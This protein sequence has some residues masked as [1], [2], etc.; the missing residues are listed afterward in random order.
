ME[1]Q[2]F[3]ELKYANSESQECLRIELELVWTAVAAQM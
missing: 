2:E 3:T 1:Q